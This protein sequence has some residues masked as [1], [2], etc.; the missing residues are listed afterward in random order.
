MNTNQRSFY[1][2]NSVKLVPLHTNWL[3]ICFNTQCGISLA[4]DRLSYFAGWSELA[5]FP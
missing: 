3:H 4:S 2:L 1:V 5:G